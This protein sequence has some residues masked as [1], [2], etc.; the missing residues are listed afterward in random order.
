MIEICKKEEMDLLLIAGDLFHRQPL[1]RELKEVGYL[2]GKL[3]HTQVVLT[4]GN[5]D[6]I[7][8]DSYYRAYS[9][10]SNVHVLLEETLETI[11]F[12]E[13]ETAVSGFSYHKREIKECTCQEKNAEHKQKYEVLLLHGGDE[14]HVPFQKEKLLKCG[15]DY[16]AL[17]HIH[18]PQSLV[19]DKIAY[20]GALEPIDKNDVGQHGY[21]IGEITECGCKTR[22]VPNA[23]REYCHVEVEVT[24][25]MTG[26]ALREKIDR[27]IREN[28][29]QNMYK[30]ILTGFR[31]PEVRF[32]LSGMDIY[33]NIIEI[34]DE[35]APAYDFERI[36]KNNAHNILGYFIQELKGYD[37]ESIEYG[38]M[39]EGVKALM[40]TRRD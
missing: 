10:P 7:K 17:G 22:F 14:S 37:R 36:M 33:G 40:E 31:D 8:A 11:E 26:F 30:I 18:K 12:P 9:W 3:S 4:A 27:A 39:C 25:D 29:Q 21:I 38:A 15:Y 20:C 13:F 5:H 6:Y 35:T 19:K 16:I 32:D 23:K 34:S 1:L 24:P 28:G 2:L